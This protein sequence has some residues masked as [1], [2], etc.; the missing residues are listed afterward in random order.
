MHVGSVDRYSGG[1]KRQAPATFRCR[2]ESEACGTAC[3]TKVSRCLAL[4]I[5]SN[6]YQRTKISFNCIDST[7][8]Q[9]TDKK[10]W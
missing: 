10:D 4:V 2:A 7:P 8:L 3:M 5:K 6:G 9:E 1:V